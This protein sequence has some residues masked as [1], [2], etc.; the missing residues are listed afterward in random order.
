M[1][2]G[3]RVSNSDDSDVLRVVSQVILIH[4]EIHVVWVGVA[5]DFSAEDE[6]QEDSSDLENGLSDNIAIDD[7]VDDVISASFRESVEK[8]VSRS[9]S[10]KG[11]SSKGVHDQIDPKDL[12]RGHDVCAKYRSSE[13]YDSHCDDVD[14]ALEL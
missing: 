3:S 12:D 11:K 8:H 9:F 1:K 10:C 2:F 6:S 14:S 4:V 5:K 7:I 13:Q